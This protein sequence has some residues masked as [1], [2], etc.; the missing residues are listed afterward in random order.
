M[1]GAEAVVCAV[2]PVISS[3]TSFS[4][5]STIIA[6]GF[7]V[8]DEG[9]VVLNVGVRDVLVISEYQLIHASNGNDVRVYTFLEQP[10][11]I[12][13]TTETPGEQRNQPVQLSMPF[14]SNPLRHLQFPSTMQSASEWQSRESKWQLGPELETYALN[15][16]L[17]GVKT[18]AHQP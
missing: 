12:S 13:K 5:V 11:G 1:L 6:F 16:L 14:P 4:S 17:E 8:A 18:K 3:T 9:P 7:V 2:S 15:K 10:A